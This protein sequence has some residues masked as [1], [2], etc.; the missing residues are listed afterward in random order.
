MV[1]W[2]LTVCLSGFL[3]LCLTCCATAHALYFGKYTGSV[4]AEWL[5]DGRKMKILQPFIFIDP[6]NVE[7]LVPVGSLVDGA[8]IPKAF[9]SLIGGPFEGKY[10]DA[11]VIHDIACDE[12]RRTWE[13]VH[14]AFYNAM[15]ASGVDPLKAKVM[16]A[17]VNYFGPRW[18]I[19]RK[20]TSISDVDIEKAARAELDIDMHSRVEVVKF[21]TLETGFDKDNVTVLV[22]APPQELTK[23]DFQKLK[24]TIER[25]ETSAE[26]PM[27]LLEIRDYHQN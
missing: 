3:Y 16:Y 14:E 20:M 5:I 9:W 7:W 23:E 26:G 11:S 25:R 22:H 4:K 27:S 19:T 10:R 8:S 21:H 17:A 1:K 18:D 13:S 6:H 12:K 15:R 24:A 2:R